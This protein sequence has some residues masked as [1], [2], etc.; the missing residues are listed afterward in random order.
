MPRTLESRRFGQMEVREEAVIRFP[1][2]LPGFEELHRFL[3]L[4]L[5]ELEPVQFLVSIDDTEISFPVLPAPLCV[6]DYAP[7]VRAADL[8]P[9]RAAEG[10]AVTTYVILTFH[11]E[12]ER[13][14]ANLRAPV[15]INPASRVGRQ[16]TLSDS[17]HSLRHELVG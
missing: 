6:P 7:D 12:G 2:G 10:S 9:L 16:V 5:P 11:H 15:L 17:T 8:E 14:T 3:L 4:S 13:V 1:D